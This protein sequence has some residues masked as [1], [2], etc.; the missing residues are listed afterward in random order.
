[1]PDTDPPSPLTLWLE[2]ALTG[3]ILPVAGLLLAGAAWGLY[4]LGL[5]PEG[6]T[7]AALAVI[8]GLVVALLMI[9]PALAAGVDRLT[10]GLAVAAALLAATV[11]AGAAIGATLPG[12]ALAEGDLARV[13]D[14]LPLPDGLSGR[15][16]LLVHA[17][18]PASGTPQADFRLGG[19]AAPLEGRVERTVSSVRVGRG[20]RANVTHDLDETWL[21]GAVGPASSALRLERLSGQLAGPLHVAVYRDLLPP[22]AAWLI[23]GVA[24]A[25]AAVAESRL[26]RGSVAP[27]AGM[28]A[29]YGLLVAGNATPAQAVGTSLGAVLLGGL[30]GALAGGLAA[31][32]ARLGPWRLD[33]EAPA[34]RGRQ[35]RA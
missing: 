30:G 14:T 10:R 15:A 28:A 12:T 3:W 21:H 26:R 24:L 35:R 17:R 31:M 18:L 27:L 23:A 16:K 29:G 8:V 34:A 5:L 20:N 32:L 9:R 22:G 33:P 4:V 2:E 11:G 25:A 7:A 1:M 6:P 13:G 19:T